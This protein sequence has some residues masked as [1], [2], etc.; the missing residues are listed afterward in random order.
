[1]KAFLLAAGEGRR[2]KP[3][4]DVVPKCLVPIHG[5]PLLALWLRLLEDHGV[6]EVLINTHHHHERVTEFLQSF[7]TPLAVTTVY[8]PRLLGSAGT[9]LANRQFV[10]GEPSF[11]VVYADN[12]TNANLT[13]LIHVHAQRSE[14]LTMGVATTD[15]PREK[16]T[17]VV[18]AAGRAIEFA[19]KSPEPKS[20]LASVGIYVASQALFSYLPAA[21]PPAGVLD[22]GCDVL[23]RMVPHLA[24]C[25]IE[26]FLIDIGTPESYAIGE[27]QWPGLS[28]AARLT[29]VA[30]G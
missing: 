4:T 17:V 7:R 5:T 14:P 18:D 3:L 21:V 23:P 29:A 1:M 22:F 30:Q 24:V 6:T 26:D 19:E 13:K 9:V 8:E 10:A 27:A 15:R 20:N 2:L 16:G 28:R 12:L 25:Q 11:L